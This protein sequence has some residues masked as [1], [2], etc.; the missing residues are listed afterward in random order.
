MIPDCDTYL[1]CCG[2]SLRHI[3]YD[4]ELIVKEKS[5]G[6]T[7]AGIDDFGD[8]KIK[9]IIDPSKIIFYRNK[10]QISTRKIKIGN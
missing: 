1:K 5:K 2:C 9:D 6:D 3:N 7:I 10:S 4:Y 8:I